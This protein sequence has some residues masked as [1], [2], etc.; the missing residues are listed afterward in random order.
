MDNS[1]MT[2]DGN[3]VMI[4][5]SDYSSYTGRVNKKVIHITVVKKEVAQCGRELRLTILNPNI[6]LTVKTHKTTNQFE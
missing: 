5:S 1:Q 3:S 6:S 4:Y 2:A